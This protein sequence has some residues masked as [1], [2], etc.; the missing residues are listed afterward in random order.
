MKIPVKKTTCAVM[1]GA[2]LAS[3]TGCS[4]IEDIIGKSGKE[5]TTKEV[6]DTFGFPQDIVD[7]LSAYWIYVGNPTST[8]PF[9]IN[10]V[11]MAD[12]F[13][14]SFIPRHRSHEM[15]MRLQQKVEENGAQIEFRQEVEKIAKID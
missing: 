15:S 13:R 1:A 7:I 12:Y 11:L 4:Q 6:M 10:A 2:I 5:D 9:T 3:M 14:G 8:L